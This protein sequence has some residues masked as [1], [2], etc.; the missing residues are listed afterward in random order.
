MAIRIDAVLESLGLIDRQKDLL[1]VARAAIER[2]QGLESDERKISMTDVELD[3]ALAIL[4]RRGI[5]GPKNDTSL[6]GLVA[7][8]ATRQAAFRTLTDGSVPVRDI[9]VAVMEG[10]VDVP[11]PEPE[12]VVTTIAPDET[13]LS[14]RRGRGRP[15]NE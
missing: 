2:A 14:R 1:Q 5:W 10:A 12:P 9:V 4:R 8:G 15:R 3:R 11:E 7:N 13:E 6:K